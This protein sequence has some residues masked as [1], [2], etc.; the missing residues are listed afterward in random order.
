MKLYYY[1]LCLLFV[2][3]FISCSE[4]EMPM[5]SEVPFA[6]PDNQ[7]AYRESDVF[8]A[9]S[10][11]P[12]DGA[13]ALHNA[14]FIS[15]YAGDSLGG[16]VSQIIERVENLAKQNAAY[17]FMFGTNIPELSDSRILYLLDNPFLKKEEVITAT[18]SGEEARNSFT[19]FSD[20]VVTLY[21]AQTD[22]TVLYNYII[23]YE[24]GILENTNLNSLDKQ[25]ILVTSSIARFAVATRPKK[26]KRNTDPE[27]DLM[28]GN[29][30]GSID[31]TATSIE[32][33]VLMSLISGIVQNP[34]K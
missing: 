2:P 9:N 11:N 19:E 14:L 5:R 34:Q 30:T 10:D 1:Y 31:G 22:T 6:I 21:S 25:K 7:N 8:P 23:G 18:F 13:G 24:A 32:K 12:Y 28:V 17:A 29:I 33:A 20:A 27:W 4:T 26:P 3:F 15:Y 16:S